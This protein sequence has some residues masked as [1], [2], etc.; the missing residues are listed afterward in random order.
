[1]FDVIMNRIQ[2]LLIL[3][4]HI[5]FGKCNSLLLIQRVIIA[6]ESTIFDGYRYHCRLL[7]IE[8][9]FLP[10]MLTIWPSLPM[11]LGTLYRPG[12]GTTGSVCTLPSI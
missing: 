10:L 4:D 2:I 9:L 8:S 11:T 1:M 6:L 3:R 5:N 12:P 7:L